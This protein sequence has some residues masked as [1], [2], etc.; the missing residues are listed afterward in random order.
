[1]S[2]FQAV[3]SFE[4]LGHMHWTDCFSLPTCSERF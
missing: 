3:K 2:K 4:L 1:M